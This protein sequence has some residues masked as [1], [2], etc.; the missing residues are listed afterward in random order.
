MAHNHATVQESY[1]EF[2]RNTKT[3]NA[4]NSK[5]KKAYTHTPTARG[6]SQNPPERFGADD[7]ARYNILYGVKDAAEEDRKG[8]VTADVGFKMNGGSSAPS[9][10]QRLG[11]TASWKSVGKMSKKQKLPARSPTHTIRSTL[12]PSP[13]S[14][15]HKPQ[16]QLPS[17]PR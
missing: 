6:G 16:S 14:I 15:T 13:S 1:E 5:V 8:E 17:S 10:Y 4:G 11:G 3:V 9:A 2:K 12:P 7:A